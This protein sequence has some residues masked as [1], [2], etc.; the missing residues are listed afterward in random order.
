[1]SHYNHRTRAQ[2]A[3]RR[4]RARALVCG[5]VRSG[6][7]VPTDH[8]HALTDAFTLDQDHA[9]P[10]PAS[11]AGERSRRLTSTEAGGGS[12]GAEGGVYIYPSS[13]HKISHRG[14]PSHV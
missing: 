3:D 10:N 5:L 14:A 6:A 9:P 1:M 12:C 13:P 7:L 11:G 4:R 2:M 8:G